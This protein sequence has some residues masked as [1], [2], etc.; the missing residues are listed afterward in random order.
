MVQLGTQRWLR[1]RL[2]R[3][4]D[5]SLAPLIAA[6][7]DQQVSVVLPAR[8]EAATVGVIV[9]ALV[10]H[11][12]EPG[13]VD[14]ILVVDSHST[15]DTPAVAAAAGATVRSQ[16]SVLPELGDRPGKGEAL[17]KALAASRGD[18]LVFLDA[19]LEDFD[20]AYVVGLLG[21]LLLDESV[22]FVKAVY[23]RP[24]A[25]GATVLP[26]GGGRVTELVA[27]PLLNA[28]WP[29][30]AGVVQPLAGEYA[31][32][33]SV[34]EQVPFVS[35]YGVELGLLIDLLDLVGLDALAQV[36]LGHRRHHHQGDEAL[37]RMAMQIQLA[38]LRR[39]PGGVEPMP[40]TPELV[41]FR[42]TDDRFV[43]SEKRV[44]ISERPPLRDVEQYRRRRA[45][46]R[47]A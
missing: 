10:R 29:E 12:R 47:P 9:E 7:G 8:N 45:L 33:R 40:A 16:S 1:E 11:L 6:K 27:R 20:P 42:R 4:A 28:F 15:D 35:G 18:L 38:A 24:L 46:A 19:D 14:E 37:G 25:D 34:L 5:F 41:Q 32:R 36:D 22:A 43:R 26:A 17:W 39:L 21:P 23:D 44:E 30:L 31:G 3:G 2:Y 13:L